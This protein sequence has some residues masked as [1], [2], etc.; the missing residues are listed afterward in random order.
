MPKKEIKHIRFYF[1]ETLF[2]FPQRTVL[3]KFISGIFKKEGLKAGAINYIFC[4][5]EYLLNLNKQYLNHNTYTDIITFQYSWSPQPIHS[6]IYISI[7]RVK[8]NA[9]LYNVPFLKELHRVLFHGA[10]HLC[11]YKDKT[12]KAIVLMR[13]KEDFYLSLYVSREKKRLAGTKH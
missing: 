11:G 10:L 8:E 1:E 2:Y 4:R 3:K 9:Q 13:S 12:K 5:D 7:D 6:D